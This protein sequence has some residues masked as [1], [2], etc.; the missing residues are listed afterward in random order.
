MA[1]TKEQPTRAYAVDISGG[2]DIFDN[3]AGDESR[4]SGPIIYVGVAGDVKVDTVGGDTVTFKA[5]QGFLPVQ[6]TK[7]YQTGTTATDM[8][9]CW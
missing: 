7:V 6:V 5:G 4:N 1:Q 9:W 3:P 2:D 8:L